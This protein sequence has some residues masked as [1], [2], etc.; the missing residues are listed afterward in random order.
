MVYGPAARELEVERAPLLMTTARPPV[1]PESD[2][3]AQSPENFSASIWIVGKR[4]GFRAVRL[5]PV[6]AGPGARR[7]CVSAAKAT[8]ELAT[9]DATT[10]AI[11]RDRGVRLPLDAR[12]RI[13]TLSSRPPQLTA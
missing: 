3:E 7:G 1:A 10:S 2:A 12:M 5:Y 6:G 9:T 11:R 8:V 4:A 13:V